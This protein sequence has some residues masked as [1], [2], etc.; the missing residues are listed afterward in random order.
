MNIKSI[1]NQ[2]Y[3]TGNDVQGEIECSFKPYGGSSSREF[4]GSHGRIFPGLVD[5]N[6]SWHILEENNKSQHLSCIQRF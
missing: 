1:Q 5:L 2:T 6:N 4:V 3:M